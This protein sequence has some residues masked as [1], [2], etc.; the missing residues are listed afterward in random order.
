MV[1]RLLVS[2]R[3]SGL[4]EPVGGTPTGEGRVFGRVFGV[5]KNERRGGRSLVLSADDQNRLCGRDGLRD[6]RG[7]PAVLAGGGPSLEAPRG[8]L[9][10]RRGESLLQGA[11]KKTRAGAGRNPPHPGSDTG[12]GAG[13]LP[14]ALSPRHPGDGGMLPPGGAGEENQRPRARRAT[15]R[16]ERRRERRGSRQQRRCRHAHGER[17]GEKEEGN[18]GDAAEGRR[19]VFARDTSLA[20]VHT[21]GG[22]RSPRGAHRRAPTPSGTVAEPFRREQ[23]AHRGKRQAREKD[24]GDK[25]ISDGM[26]HRACDER[27][28]PEL[29][30]FFLFLSFF[31]SVSKAN[32]QPRISASQ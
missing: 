21:T 17:E 16:C 20:G 12:R 19:W 18:G 5:P 23:R 28:E 29:I 15:R 7:A 30:F 4:A 32:R 3:L 22:P 24:D 25:R 13:S 6:D 27:D 26:L 8:R 10:S 2:V 11:R 14:G 31:D 1:L 9:C